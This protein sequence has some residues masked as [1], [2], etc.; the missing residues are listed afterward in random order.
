MNFFRSFFG[1]CRGPYVI[2]DLQK[3]SWGRVI[4]HVALICLICSIVIGIGNYALI[5]F[6]WRAAYS[7]FNEIFGSRLDGSADGI[8]PVKNPEKSRRQELPYNTLLIYV[9][10]EGPEV[11][12]DETLRDRNIIVLW[13]GAGIAVFTRNQNT[14]Q[15]VIY[16]PDGSFD[17][18]PDLLSYDDMKSELLKISKLPVSGK[19]NFT[20]TISSRQLFFSLRFSYAMLTALRYFISGLF[21]IFFFTLFF[22]VVF[23]IFSSTRRNKMNIS[24]SKLWKTALYTAFPVLLVVSLFPALQL[25]GSGHYGN[26]FV[27]GWALYVF[28]VLKYQISNPEETNNEDKEDKNGTI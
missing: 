4:W 10:P 18:S 2:Y 17:L 15:Q 20:E 25:P 27:I 1:I 6:R 5:N 24:F 22:A 7:N 26:L 21:M 9:S 16:N 19:W 14:W 3:N 28:F 13:S 8:Y 23:K 12:P 11:Y